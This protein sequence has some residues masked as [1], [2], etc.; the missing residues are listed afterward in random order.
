VCVCEYVAQVWLRLITAST[1]PGSMTG[2]R[3]CV[4]VWV[5]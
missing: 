4:C 1:P 3:V 5:A 2:I